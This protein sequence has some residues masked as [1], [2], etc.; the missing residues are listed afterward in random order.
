MDA[1]MKD[2]TLVLDIEI[3]D[4]GVAHCRLLDGDPLVWKLKLYYAENLIFSLAGFESINET[5][6]FAKDACKIA[7]ILEGNEH[8]SIEDG[9]FVLK[10]PGHKGFCK[11]SLNIGFKRVKEWQD[12]ERDSDA[13]EQSMS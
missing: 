6:E 1:K 8:L 11:A 13:D 9:K 12:K 3:G 7:E 10:L 5:F 4:K 2:G